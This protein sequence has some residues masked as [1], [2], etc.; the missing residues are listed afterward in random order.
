MTKANSPLPPP[1]YNAAAFVRGKK[2]V[3]LGEKEQL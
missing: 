2:K 1:N 3:F